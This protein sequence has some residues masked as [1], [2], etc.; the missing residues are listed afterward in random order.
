MNV[1]E[2]RNTMTIEELLEGIRD[3]EKQLSNFISFIRN[4]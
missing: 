4:S 1:D 3:I 2:I